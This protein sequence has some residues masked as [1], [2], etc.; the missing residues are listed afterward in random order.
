MQAL[1]THH[2]TRLNLDKGLVGSF[3]QVDQKSPARICNSC[4]K[5]VTNLLSPEWRQRRYE[6]N[7]IQCNKAIYVKPAVASLVGPTHA[8]AR[9]NAF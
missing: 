3:D 5:H 2:C 6:Q 9:E 1:T 4:R 7:E 8:I